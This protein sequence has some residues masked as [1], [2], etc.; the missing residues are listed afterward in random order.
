M[1]DRPQILTRIYDLLLYILPVM[2]AFPRNQRYN[3][4]E[5]IERLALDIFELILEA[6]YTK[7]KLDLLRK[8]NLSLEKLRLLFR[9]SK[10]LRLINLHRF[11]VVTKMLHEIGLDVS[12]W[13]MTN[14]VTRLDSGQVTIQVGIQ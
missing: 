1:A 4:G 14:T 6:L 8:T 12:G 11:E 3:L 10:D 9:L 2:A 7:D 13:I 5:R